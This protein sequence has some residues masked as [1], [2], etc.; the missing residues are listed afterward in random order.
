ML[1][2]RKNDR[3]MDSKSSENKEDISAVHIPKKRLISSDTTLG[4][5]NLQ[6]DRLQPPADAQEIRIDF[7]NFTAREAVLDEEF[8][9]SLFL[10]ITKIQL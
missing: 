10:V 3:A 7:G 6:F 5:S 1:I 4:V 9:V 2:L 8:W